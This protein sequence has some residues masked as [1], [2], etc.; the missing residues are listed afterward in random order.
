[1]PA[2]D[3]DWNVEINAGFY[4][5]SKIFESKTTAVVNS[6]V[7]MIMMPDAV[8]EKFEASLKSSLSDYTID[9]SGL[10]CTSDSTC[11]EIAPSMSNIT[12]QLA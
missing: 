5:R 3:T 2:D 4:G 10:Y 9:C 6:G 1:M 12:F 7:S 8:F 11:E